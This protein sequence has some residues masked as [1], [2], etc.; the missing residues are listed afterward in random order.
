M[1]KLN[2]EWL[3]GRPNFYFTYKRKLLES[4]VEGSC[5]SVGYGCI[6]DNAVNI[7]GEFSK[8][9][10]GDDSFDTV[11]C[12]DALEFIGPHKQAINELLR[13]ARKKIVIT[14]PA[15]KWL[16][17][18]YDRLLGHRR[19]YSAND[20]SGF[21]ITHL[22]WFLVPVLSLRKI[23]GLKHRPLPGWLDKLFFRMS[24]LRL[25][26]G[27]TILA[28]KHKVDYR[29][30]EKHHVSVFVPIFNE[31][32]T[33]K[34]S[35]H[36]LEY[37][38]RKIPVDYEIFIVNDASR[39]QTELISRAIERSNRKVSLLNYDIGP[40]RRENL[41]Q[42]FKKA[43]G[44][45][46]AFV[47]VDAVRSLRF[48]KDLIDQVV[49]GYDIVTGSR[50]LAGAKRKRS[51]F[52]L[53]IS[54]AY[55]FFIRLMFHT[56]IADHMCG[57]KAFKKEVILALVEEMGYDR[58]LRRGV[59]WDTELLLRAI[60]HGYKIKEIPIWWSERYESKLYFKREILAARYILDFIRVF[61]R[62]KIDAQKIRQQ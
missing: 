39:D 12:S 29:S 23:F 46:I 22:F 45:I 19:R 33:L 61:N 40:T 31:E 2:A 28:V 13:V 49:C 51:L 59:F 10:F 42:S 9:P 44:D 54:R 4:M 52:R 30:G 21:E 1:D 20:F 24:G 27:T 41:A 37:I 6:I 47:D 34:R 18:K 3:K 8:L 36:T 43:G 32:S 58:S 25:N 26:F 16:Y 7:G 35:I 11:I 14:V 5:L 55:N 48:L 38:I 60:R 53:S 62:E 15:Y 56:G 50:Y 17:G 57:F